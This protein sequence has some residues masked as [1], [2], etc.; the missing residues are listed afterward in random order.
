MAT[1]I[2]SLF[3]NKKVKKDV[4]MTGEITITGRILPIGGLK[5]KLLAAR[6]MNIKTVIIPKKNENDLIKLPKGLKND[7]KI[8][9]VERFDEVI[10]IAIE[11]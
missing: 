8:I 2:F 11:E 9:P 1:G 7:I 6:R 3:T 10:N 4:A 5:E